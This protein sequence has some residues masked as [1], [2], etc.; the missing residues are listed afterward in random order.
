M[1]IFINENNLYEL[2]HASAV[3]IDPELFFGI[4]WEK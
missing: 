3:G 1:K 4:Q 2:I